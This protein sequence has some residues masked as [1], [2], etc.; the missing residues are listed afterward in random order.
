MYFRIDTSSGVPVYEQIV[1][2]VISMRRAGLLQQGETLPSV[3]ELSSHMVIN[4]NTA[5]KA[6]R[7][8]EDSGMVQMQGRSVIITDQ[9][10]PE[11]A[12]Q[13][14]ETMKRKLKRQLFE[15]RAAGMSEEEL[16]SFTRSCME[17]WGE[18]AP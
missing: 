1:H 11:A 5:A 17:E 8:L 10:P 9:L 14:K 12:E 6:Y 15:A 7:A 16:L 4:P 3:R 13:E 18:S 2:Q